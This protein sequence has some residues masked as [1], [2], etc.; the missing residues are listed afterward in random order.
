MT[1]VILESIRAL[2]LLA[3]FLFLLRM[4]KDIEHGRR[5]W[6]FIKAG[7]FLILIGSLVDITDNYTSLNWTIVLGDTPAQAFI[8][9]VVGYLLG[10]GLLAI[11]FWIWLPKIQSV[12]QMKKDLQKEKERADFVFNHAPIGISRGENGSNTIIRN[13]AFATALGYDSAEELH[14]QARKNGGPQFLWADKEFLQAT[15]NRLRTERTISA[16]E[17]ELIHKDGSKIL[18]LLDFV[19]GPDEDG[20]NIFFHCFARN[21]T[22]Q[23]RMLNSLQV[24]EDRL[25]TIMESLPA[26]VYLVNAEDKTIVDINTAAAQMVG[27]SREEIIGTH[28]RAKLCP[29]RTDQCIAMGK[30]CSKTHEG[31]FTRK[32]GTDFP[33]L[34]TVVKLTMQGKPYYLET[35]IDITDQKRLEQFKEDVDHIVQHDLRSPVSSVINAA[36]IA[37]MNDDVQGESREMLEIIKSKGARILDLLAIS[38]VMYK[39]EAGAYEY[40]PEN[41]DLLA[42]IRSVLAEMDS[43]VAARNVTVRVTLDGSPIATGGELPLM[44][45]NLLVQ[46]IITNILTNAVEAVDN[47]QS[48]FFDI[49]TNDNIILRFTNPGVVPEEIRNVFFNKYITSGKT[50]GTGLGTYSAKLVTTTMGGKIEMQTSDETHQTII[51]VTLPN[52]SL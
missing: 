52:D 12:G 26:G 22:E 31:L 15:I 5:G 3:I 37:L 39:I 27:Y 43:L 48:I 45:N 44:A 46:S 33:I 7:F 32:D 28:C 19:S 17:A 20:E 4:D 47:G 1:D 36:T 29:S 23:R 51:T 6:Q 11:G 13:D 40:K 8:E 18:M 14:E 49:E 41:V 50:S 9:K 34:K 30:D 10:F 2:I 24:S 38:L 16:L 25:K 42:A 35:F 21:I